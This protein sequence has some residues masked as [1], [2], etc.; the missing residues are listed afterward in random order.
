MNKIKYLIVLCLMMIGFGTTVV[1]SQTYF[2]ARVRYGATLP[3]SCA[4]SRTGALFYKTGTNAGLY[5][6]VSGVYVSATSSGGSL[7][8]QIKV[9]NDMSGADLGAKIN[10]A[11][12]ACGATIGCEILV[13]DGGSQATNTISSRI[14]VGSNHN[15][16]FGEGTFYCNYTV[17]GNIGTI[18]AQDNTLIYGD[19]WSN[20]VIYE[21]NDPN[22]AGIYDPVSGLTNGGHTALY[23]IITSYNSTLVGGTESLSNT[24]RSYNIHVRG[25]HFKGIRTNQH[26]GGV[27]GAVTFGN[28]FGCSLTNSW[29]DEVSGYGAVFGGTADGTD[30]NDEG[31]NGTNPG[32]NYSK[33]NWFTDNLITNNQSQSLAVINSE[34]V[35]VA[36]NI[37]R[38][39][40]KKPYKITNISNVN[41]QPIVVTL[42]EAHHF[43]G[44]RNY[45]RLRGVAATGSAVEID[46]NTDYFLKPVT[47]NSFQLISS[48]INTGTVG[49][50]IYIT[51][52]LGT[53]TGSYT[54]SAASKTDWRGIFAVG[55]DFEPNGDEL[56]RGQQI[57]IEDNLFDF[58]VTN[59]MATFAILYQTTDPLV[60]DGNA[61]IRNNTIIGN[62]TGTGTL[63][64]GINVAY[65]ATSKMTISE[66]KLDCGAGNNSG[67]L[68]SGSYLTINSNSMINCGGGGSGSLQTSGL[69]FSTVSGN[70]M[71]NPNFGQSGII[72]R[73][74]SNNNQ[75]FNNQTATHIHDA[76]STI[77][78]SV[79]RNNYWVNAQNSGFSE[80]SGSSN[81]NIFINNVTKP[82][83]APNGNAGLVI[84]GAGSKVLSHQ[85]T[86][87]RTFITNL[88]GVSTPFTNP[89]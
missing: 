18:L 88:N 47:A 56:E 46:P 31:G 89:N 68:A 5:Q 15:L 44:G 30:G 55:I 20:T 79:Y 49:D 60:A 38:E 8:A 66:N 73:G 50:P 86:D 71:Q 58:S 78:N 14:V 70:T 9:A 1:K 84:F 12:T 25:I 62:K 29:L 45:I 52:I 7:P 32:G 67:I 83:D 43:Y 87:G 76:T 11:N 10:A 81:N 59:G 77:T 61:K 65:S 17:Q 4:T 16:H 54:L 42:N 23:R 2:D 13:L 33:D 21:T 35:I 69:T 28:C 82:K 36:R 41:G 75:W 64:V 22:V 63:S 39:P 3:T 74:V 85:Y 19:G 24:R 27:A 51:P 48:T 57:T 72:E 37:F 26:D 40:G 6:C 53:P 80:N 34:N